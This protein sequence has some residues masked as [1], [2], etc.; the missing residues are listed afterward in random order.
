MI[1]A[2]RKTVKKEG[3]QGLFKGFGAVGAMTMPAHALYFG[4][5]EGSKMMLQR[6]RREDEK[7][8]WVYFVSG[9]VA[10][11][12]GSLIWTPMDVIK[13]RVQIN[14]SPSSSSL[15]STSTTGFNSSWLALTGILK[16]EGFF[17]LYRGL[18]VALATFGPYVGLYFTFYEQLKLNLYPY[19]V[20]MAPRTISSSNHSNSTSNDS[21]QDSAE[22]SV[23]RIDANLNQGQSEGSSQSKSLSKTTHLPLNLFCA[24]IGASLSALITCPIDVVKTNMQ[25]YS[26]KEGGQSST[27]ETIKALYRDSLRLHRLDELN[28]SAL[29]SKKY[30]GVEIDWKMK[31]RVCKVFF[32]GWNAR[33]LWLAPG[34]AITMAAYE[35][36]KSAVSFLL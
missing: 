34:S 13:Q 16:S 22:L 24:F 27:I 33:I 4:G 36:C 17:G 35:Q 15:I 3:L 20:A 26:V 32:R 21:N 5:Y 2:F 30:H 14:Q 19:Y 6:D 28:P 29:N 23:S 9:F 25:V 31:L 11:I 18:P 10:D 7:S 8:A 12:F 1:D